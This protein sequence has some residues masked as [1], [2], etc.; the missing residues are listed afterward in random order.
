MITTFEEVYETLPGDGWLTRSEAELL[1]NSALGCL[2]PI[3]EVGCYK[4]R[5]TC[6]LAALGR[7]V[8]AVDPFDGFTED[9]TGDEIFKA[10]MTN[11]SSRHLHNVLL[12]R[13][14]VE[15]WY[16]PEG[17]TIRFAYLDG[18][19]TRQGTLNQISKALHAGARVIAIHDV[20]D[21]GGGLQVKEA[22]LKLLGPWK[23]RV[24][25]LAVWDLRTGKLPNGL[26]ELR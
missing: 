5:S 26:K 17:V 1:W 6:L 12:S 3:L 13:K 8:Y 2:G 21:S 7:P 4:G 16:A 25:R 11:L 23:E 9:H 14:S 20:N 15:E 22:A 24:E 19:H 10:F 18:D